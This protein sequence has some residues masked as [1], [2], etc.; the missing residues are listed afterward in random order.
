MSDHCSHHHSHGIAGTGS[1]PLAITLSLVTLYFLAELIGGLWTGSLALLADAGH[2]FSDMAA[3]SISLLAAWLSKKEPTPQRTFGFHRAEVLA[4]LTNGA[5]LFLVAGGILHEAW[6]RLNSPQE[7]LAGP[8]L[9]IALGGL[10]INLMSL[11][12]LHGD[13]HHNLNLRGAW[14]HVLGDTLGS[15]GVI[16]AALLVW[17][18]Q[19]TWADPVASV[20]VC[21]LILYS[22]WNLLRES[23]GILMQNAPSDVDVAA[24]EQLILNQPAVVSLHCLHIWLIASGM[25]TLT[26]HV[27]INQ[28]T[29]EEFSLVQLNVELQKNFGIEHVTIQIE[30][31]DDPVCSELSVAG[32]LHYALNVESQSSEPSSSN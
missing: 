2:M 8:M 5:L 6:E 32:S 19:W 30:S 7:I 22:S 12:I 21:L 26:A 20:L 13:H 23:A 1:R 10:A 28:N 14:L 9:W 11:K 24:V 17:Q 25:K 27:V 18:L 16:L 15:V 3:L 4:A 31:T 29:S